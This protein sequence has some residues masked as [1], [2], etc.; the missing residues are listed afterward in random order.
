V[1]TLSDLAVDLKISDGG[2]G[3]QSFLG[4]D[5]V[6]S[7]DSSCAVRRGVLSNQLNGLGLR[8]EC[9]EFDRDVS[10]REGTGGGVSLGASFRVTTGERER[11][12]KNVFFLLA[13]ASER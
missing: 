3:D 2:R 8:V 5:D 6:K 1:S 9:P 10:D 7:E 12:P 4:W 11:R 13:V